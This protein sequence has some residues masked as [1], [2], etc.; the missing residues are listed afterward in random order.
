MYRDNEIMHAAARKLLCD[1]PEHFLDPNTNINADTR[2]LQVLALHSSRF[3]L[4]LYAEGAAKTMA[5]NS[6]K[7]HMR[8]LTD[9]NAKTGILKS[10]VPSEPILAVA[11]GWLLLSKQEVYKA[12]MKTLVDEILL[13]DNIV[14]LGDKGETLARIILIVTRD[15]TVHAAGGQLCVV[16]TS[17]STHRI[18]EET[19][20]QGSHLRSAVRPFT[21]KSFLQNLVN[22]EGHIEY[23][24]LQW[25]EGVHLNFTHFAQLSNSVDQSVT[26]EFLVMCWQRGVALQCVHNQAIIDALLVGYHG[27]LS[28]PFDPQNFVFVVLQFKNR[29]GA[30]DLTLIQNMTTPFIKSGPTIWK[31]D[32][33][34]IL[35]DLGTSACFEKKG[36]ERVQVTKCRAGEGKSWSAFNETQELEAVRISIRGYDPYLSL[37]QWAPAMLHVRNLKADNNGLSTVSHRWES[38]L[39]TF[40]DVLGMSLENLEARHRKQQKV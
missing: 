9:Y 17:R 11:A 25:A 15:A 36:G 37:A 33:M 34:A 6:V 13:S 24:D 8:L 28:K 21:L 3:I 1:K 30:T 40:E 5:I 12:A 39:N 29:N 27:D 2:N 14:C 31:P 4:N 35:M 10:S 18:T 19:A 7:S 23:D 20:N 32:Y 16:D 26:P 22:L 38:T